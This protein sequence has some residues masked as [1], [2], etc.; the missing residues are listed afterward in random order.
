MLIAV[1]CMESV[2]ADIFM[3]V[4]GSKFVRFPIDMK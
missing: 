2:P 3:P 1:L 4:R